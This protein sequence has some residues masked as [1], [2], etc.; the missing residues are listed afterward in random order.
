MSDE[1]TVLTIT[2]VGT[3]SGRS[4]MA[5]RLDDAIVDVLSREEVKGVLGVQTTAVKQKPAFS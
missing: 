1:V 3:P 2:I 4:K 5:D